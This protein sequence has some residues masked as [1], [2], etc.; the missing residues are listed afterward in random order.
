ME[1]FILAKRQSKGGRMAEKASVGITEQLVEWGFE[2]DRLK[3]G[4]LQESMAGLLIILKWKNKKEMKKL[5][6]FL[7]L[8][9]KKPE[10][11]RSCWIT[12]TNKEVHDILKQVLMKVPCS[13]EEYKAPDQDI[14]QVLKIK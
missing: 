10:K 1:L 5:S 7:I 3:T 2:S 4:T 6:D 14:V 9:T 11:Q 13:R 12:Y 8:D